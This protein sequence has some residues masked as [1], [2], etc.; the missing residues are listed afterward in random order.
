MNSRLR[1]RWSWGNR[2]R[3]CRSCTCAGLQAQAA[4]QRGR[5]DPAEAS[6]ICFDERAQAALA[7]PLWPSAAVSAGPSS[8]AG[9]TNCSDLTCRV[10]NTGDDFEH[11]GLMISPDVDTVLYTL[12]NLNDPERGW[13][14]ADETWNF[15][16]ALARRRRDLVQSRRSR[17][18]LACRARATPCGRAEP[19]ARHCGIWR[20]PS[21]FPRPSCRCRMMRCV[22]PS[23]RTRG[24]CRFKS[25][26]SGCAARPLYGRSASKAQVPRVCRR[27]FAPR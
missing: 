8:P 9:F 27:T 5:S 17:S 20:A 3:V 21:A 13:G 24:G 14:R 6:G 18:R 25:I 22:R 19:H 4:Q 23:I 16:S 26:L 15:M 1:P 10:V 7:R 12:A 2:R 11:L